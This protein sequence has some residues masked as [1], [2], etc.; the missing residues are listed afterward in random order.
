MIINFDTDSIGSVRCF[1][2]E[3]G[4]KG[5]DAKCRFLP[6]L[7]GDEHGGHVVTLGG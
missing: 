6:S 4:E 7:G 2:N 5:A 1:D 3:Q